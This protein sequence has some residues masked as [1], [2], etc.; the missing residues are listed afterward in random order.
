MS[1]DKLL[2]ELRR[3]TKGAIKDADL[4]R[5]YYA[6]LQLGLEKKLLLEIMGAAE[7]LR[8]ISAAAAKALQ[9]LGDGIRKLAEELE[10]VE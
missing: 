4:L 9:G 6:G 2:E 7:A 1:E 8:E 3:S 10:K 5:V